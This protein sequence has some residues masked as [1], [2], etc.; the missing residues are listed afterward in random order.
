MKSDAECR[1]TR[2]WK[3][4]KD[5]E[6]ILDVVRARGHYLRKNKSNQGGHYIEYPWEVQCNQFEYT[7]LLEISRSMKREKH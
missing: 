7:E 1:S 4:R 6:D 2:W 5:H 3:I